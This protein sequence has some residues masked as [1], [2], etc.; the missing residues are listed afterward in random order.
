MSA[1]PQLDFDVMREPWNKYHVSDGAYIKTKIVV[2]KIRK[3]MTG[4]KSW[5]YSDDMQS[6]IV[7]LSDVQGTP[8]TKTYSPSEID[9]ALI[10]NELRY[11]IVS[12]EW[13]EYIIDDG[14]RLG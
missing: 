4:E 11:T 1:K 7:T 2:T 13:N 9:A 12:E 8:D 3:K 6:I 14:A 10:N 5:E